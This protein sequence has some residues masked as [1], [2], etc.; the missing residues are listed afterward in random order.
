MLDLMRAHL[1]DFTLLCYASEDLREPEKVAVERHLEECSGCRQALVEIH[2]LDKELALLAKDPGANQ[3]WHNEELPI[4]DPFRQRPIAARRPAG[5][6]S[7]MPADRL[8]LACAAS[9][10]AL[11]TCSALLE[12]VK[13]PGRDLADLFSHLSLASLTDRFALLYALQEAGQEIAEN[14]SRFMEF[15]EKAFALLEDSSLSQDAPHPTEEERV[16]PSLMLRARAHQLAG[17]ARL[18]TGEFEDAGVHFRNAY[19]ASGVT[20]DETG[21]A[22]V[23][24]LEAQRRFFIGRGEEALV[25]ARRAHATFAMLGLEDEQARCRGAEGMALFQLGRFEESAQAFRSALGT[26]EAYQLWSNYVG[27]LNSIATALVKMGRLDEA[28]REYAG[29]LRRLSRERHRSW[30]PFIR[31][32]L[33]EVLFSA[34]RYREAATQASRAARL[35]SESGQLSRSLTASLFEVESWARAGDFVRA[36]HRLD[37]FRSEIAQHGK[38]DP[39]LARL[40][41]QALSGTSVDF[42]KIAE[43]REVAVRALRVSAGEGA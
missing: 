26:F 6:T 22:R 24:Q 21:T 38:L 2:R 40:I 20:G 11:A 29:A 30:L 32:G 37:I 35:F 39:T 27:T 14:P 18:W 33:A 5:K 31:K 28:R 25:L 23:E 9:E 34:G 17:Q 3:D 36:R 13:N 16:V 42:R 10:N 1:D 15:A 7:L 19:R 4:G 12:A 41:D 8:K 43:L